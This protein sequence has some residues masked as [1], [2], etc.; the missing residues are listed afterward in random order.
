MRIILSLA[1]LI[2]AAGALS[3]VGMA[4]PRATPEAPGPSMAERH[5]LGL[6]VEAISHQPC[7]LGN[8]VQRYDLGSDRYLKVRCRKADELF[9]SIITIRLG[10]GGLV[11][12]AD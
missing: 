12:Y 6:S 2:G 3:L 11:G 1:I 10:A 7:E 4:V 9:G 5:A 8:V